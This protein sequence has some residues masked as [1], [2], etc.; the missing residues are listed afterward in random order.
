MSRITAKRSVTTSFIVDLGDI[1]LNVT[2]MIITGSVILLAEALEGGSDL[3]ASG[4]LLIGLKISKKRSDKKHP[5]GF[6]KALFSW[7]LLSAMVM[8]VFGA[9]MSFYFGLKRFLE[10]HDIEHIG[11]AFGTLCISIITNGYALS[12]SA[13]RLL[14]NRPFRELKDTLVKSTHV[15]TKNTFILDL[16]GASAAIIG[17]TSLLLYQITGIKQFDGLGGMLMGVFIAVT[18]IALIWGVKD[19]LAGKSASPD[20][21]KQIKT[22]VLEVP[23]ILSILE[24]STMYMGSQ[25]L[26]LHLDVE[27]N[28][29]TTAKEITE[30]TDALKAKIKKEVPVVYSMQ[31]ETIA[32]K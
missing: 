24:L 1:G 23:Q 15:E 18:A 6:G 3:I 7:T 5:F 13:R 11:I 30:L 8:L 25:K 9:G 31:I 12:V 28:K 29:N 10:P 4:L 17:L 14:N 22:S 16:T 2:A 27:V 21:M 26:M 32:S 20:I 19:F